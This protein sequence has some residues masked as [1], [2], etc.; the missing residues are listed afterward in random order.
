MSTPVLC[1]WSWGQGIGTGQPS[2]QPVPRPPSGDIRGGTGPHC[3]FQ[4]RL[5]S[6]GSECTPGPPGPRSLL[7][8]PGLS[9]GPSR[10]VCALQSAPQLPCWGLHYHPL[11]LPSS[12]GPPRHEG[13]ME[14]YTL[15][16]YHSK[17]KIFSEK[18][19]WK[20]SVTDCD[21]SMHFRKTK[22]DPEWRFKK[23]DDQNRW[24]KT[25]RSQWR[26]ESGWLIIS[27]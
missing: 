27:A 12:I 1:P 2:T 11:C 5:V 20:V 8:P 9:S 6:T 16:N 24:G 21:W 10:P 19:K 3:S 25:Q 15:L 14:F 7:W 18:Q 22:L 17:M 23:N 13:L 4:C 26:T